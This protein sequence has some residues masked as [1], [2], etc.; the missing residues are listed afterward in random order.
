VKSSNAQKSILAAS[1]LA[2]ISVFALVESSAAYA[3]GRPRAGRSVSHT[4]TRTGAEGRSASRSSRKTITENGYQRSTTAT[5][6]NGQTAT[7]NAAGVYNADTK[8]W[9]RDAS[10]VGPNGGTSS[11][12]ATVQRTDNGYTRDVSRTGPNGNTATRSVDVQKTETGYTSDVVKTHPNGNT[13]TRNDSANY[14]PATGTLTQQRTITGPNGQ[15]STVTR[16][17]SETPQ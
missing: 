9:T 4:V 12:S 3:N 8:T 15:S 16:E 14:D 1:A 10:S 2:L 7:R 13:V 5:G 17:V 11:T 6:P